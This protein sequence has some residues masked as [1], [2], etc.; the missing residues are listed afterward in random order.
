MAVQG[1]LKIKGGGEYEIVECEYEFS[2]STDDT[3]KPTTRT[4]GGKFTF[5][6][7]TPSD[8]DQF[9]YRWMFDKTSVHS[10][11]FS[12]CVFSNDNKSRYRTVEFTHA[13]CVGLK[14]Y[15]CNHDSKLMYTTVTIS[16]EI[17]KVGGK[18]MDSAVFTNDWASMASRME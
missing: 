18:L 11:I 16:A 2:Q 12:F 10:G 5:V 7:P 14:D 15:F 13:Y 9:F 17:V 1:I 8:D 3:G 4:M 6:T